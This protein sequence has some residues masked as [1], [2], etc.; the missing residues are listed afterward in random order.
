MILI[1][2]G[3][4]V[5]WMARLHAHRP[6]DLR[7]EP[8]RL[9][10]IMLLVEIRS[11]QSVLGALQGASAALPEDDGL[12]RVA[13]VAAVSGLRDAVEHAT[14]ALRP[15][16][17]Q[18]ARAQRSGSPLVGTV[19]RLIED[20]L[21]AERAR[22]LAKARTLPTRLMLPVTLLMLPG[23]VLLLYAPSLIGLYEDLLGAWS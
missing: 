11:G 7:P 1:A 13:R 9:V 12:N 19:R 2:L 18:L 8:V 10:L 21:S 5:I 6:R 17:A 3:A 4:A 20:D 22:R 15:V 14:P 16:M 23:L